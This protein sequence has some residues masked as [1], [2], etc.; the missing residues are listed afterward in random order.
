MRRRRPSAISDA[1]TPAGL[2]SPGRRETKCAP[3][4]VALAA[5]VLWST[6]AY[7]ADL[8]L[9][10]MSL[11]W[12]LVVQFATAAVALPAVRAVRRARARARDTALREVEPSVD[13]LPPVTVLVG[14]VGLTGRSSSSTWPSPPL[15]SW[16]PT[17]SYGWPLLAALAIAATRRSRHALLSAGLAVFGGVALIFTS[18][19]PGADTGAADTASWGYLAALGSAACMAVYTLGAGH[20]P[21]SPT[22][23]LLSATV[24]GAVATGVLTA[25]TDSPAPT[26]GGVL[27]A[28]YLGLGPM[29]G[30]YA[31]WTV[32]MA[33][34]GAERLSPLGYTTPLPSTLVLLAAGAPAT[35]STLAGVGLVLACG[36]GVLIHEHR[37]ARPPSSLSGHGVN[38]GGKPPV[39]IGPHP[40]I[41]MRIRHL[42]H[43]PSQ[44]SDRTHPVTAGC[45][46]MLA[47]FARCG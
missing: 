16:Q 31:L 18:P 29:A 42:P 28:V 4:L 2:R 9:A 7:A 43:G 8:A 26:P 10:R 20:T 6:H 5:A 22:R 37:T 25:L 11:G 30:G 36:L 39:A 14:V 46:R 44:S 47:T 15:P 23:L 19:A 40:R 32:A 33:R 21:S 17:C 13:V 12:L 24:T 38:S 3:A 34:G 35:T 27:A 41:A 45:R 1:Q